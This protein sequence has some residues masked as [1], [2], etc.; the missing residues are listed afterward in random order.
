MRN[1][2][3]TL[4][5]SF[6]HFA[7]HTAPADSLFQSGVAA[8]KAE[9]FEESAEN[10]RQV[11][12]SGYHSPALYYNIGN[13]Y[14][15]L[16]EYPLAI[17]YYEKALKLDPSMENARFNLELA[18]RH[19]VDKVERLPDFFLKRF[20]NNLVRSLSSDQWAWLSFQF[21]LLG[22]MG[23]AVRRVTAKS[24]LRA[25]G[26]WTG[27]TAIGLVF[28]F[29][30]FS[31]RQKGHQDGEN[32]AIVTDPVVNVMSS[33]AET[34]SRLFVVHEGLKVE[35]TGTSEDWKEITLPNGEKGWIR[36]G[37]YQLI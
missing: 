24:L 36:S 21:L 34:G 28:L 8:Y 14:Y 18:N 4:L 22:L 37:Q 35:I 32:F 29:T 3:L 33:P 19:T 23:L 9:S 12:Q 7:G 15:R 31:I 26:K 17:L 25:A 20:W 11:L 6:L 5:L 16:E 30:L 1:L 13:S 27:I 10:F 2:A